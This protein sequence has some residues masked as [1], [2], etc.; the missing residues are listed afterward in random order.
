MTTHVVALVFRV[1]LKIIQNCNKI[2][3]SSDDQIK[4]TQQGLYGYSNGN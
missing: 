2:F 4:N 3:L 1:A